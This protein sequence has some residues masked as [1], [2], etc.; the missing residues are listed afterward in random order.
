MGLRAGLNFGQEKYFVLL[1]GNRNPDYRSIAYEL[2]EVMNRY[3]CSDVNG[4]EHLCLTFIG[5]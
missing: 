4:R 5:P 2:G 1:R 3:E